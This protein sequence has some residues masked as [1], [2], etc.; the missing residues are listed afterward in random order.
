MQVSNGPI[1]G[2]NYKAV[3]AVKI[4]LSRP[5]F[6]EPNHHHIHSPN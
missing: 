4:H 1:R 5:S 2:Y 6:V 3:S